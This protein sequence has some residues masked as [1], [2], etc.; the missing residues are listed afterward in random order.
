MKRFV[1]P[2]RTSALGVLS[3]AVALWSGWSAGWPGPRL[4]IWERH[5]EQ[6][7]LLWRGPRQPPAEVVVV[8]V[9]DASLQQAAWFE[10]GSQG[11]AVPAWARGL[12]TLPW[13]RAAYGQLSERL[14]EAGAAAVALNV[15]FEGASGRGPADDAGLQRSLA[16]S[17]GRVALAA[18]MLEPEDARGA[19]GLTLVRPELQLQALG[20]AAAIG[21]T[22]TLLP[23]PGQPLRHP[24]AYGGLVLRAQGVQ[25]P[26]SLS[27]TV[28]RLAQRST[29]Q[30]DAAAG[31]NP[32]GP[33]GSFTR[34]SAWELLDPE[35]WRGH[36]LRSRLNQA[37]VL[38]GPVEGSRLNTPFGPLSGLELLATATANSL[39]GDGLGL[40]PQQPPVRALLAAGVPLLAA[41]LALLRRR[42]RWRL[43]VVSSMLVLQL[44]AGMVALVVGHRWLPLVAPSLA[45][46]ALGLL[47]GGNA[48]AVEGRERRR[49]RRTFERYVAPSVVAE[50]LADPTSAQGMLRGRELEVTV[51]FCDLQGFTQLTR[52]RSRAGQSE[53]HVLQLNTY[54]GAMVEVITA[55]GGTVDKFIGDAVMAVFGSPVGRGCREEAAAAVRCALAMGQRLER[56]NASWAAQ[57]D[58]LGAC[59]LAN[60]V[61]LA[62]GPVV[63]GQIGSP[64]RMEFT[65][66]GDTVNRASRLE[67]ITRQLAQPICLDH[68]TAQLVQHCREIAL[69]CHGLHP[70]KGMEEQEVYSVAAAGG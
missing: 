2:T 12:D 35:R 43:A 46:V 38:V 14:L 18:E 47:Y 5:V 65:V 21:L 28:L 54:L 10:Q 24:E 64:Q 39:A 1:P 30:H 25:A 32:Y 40:W 16:R 49:L 61:G 8:A 42:F 59:P 58:A 36:A 19:G 67:G 48:Y 4:Q 29:R 37:L 20:S 11:A 13:P 62:S 3:V 60:G 50:I 22:N 56:L 9:D 70:L 69:Q 45:L 57:A 23:G 44:T 34:L 55:H 15:V 52:Q 53:L 51:L 31:L 17:R 66:I 41:A 68:A 7:M 27:S 6:Q 26:P 33:E 63:A